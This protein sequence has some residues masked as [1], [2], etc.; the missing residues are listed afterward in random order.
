MPEKFEVPQHVPAPGDT[1]VA[2]FTHHNRP[3]VLLAIELLA[4]PGVTEN[5]MTFPGAYV[6]PQVYESALLA[7]AGSGAPGGRTTVRLGRAPRAVRVPSN[8]NSVSMFSEE[9]LVHPRSTVVQGQDGSYYVC[10]PGYAYIAG[11][12]LTKLPEQEPVT[13]PQPEKVAEPRR[14]G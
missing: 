9:S 14:K 6:V 3:P 5:G 1:H 7:V 2:L 11:E 4:P 13:P 10:P 8:S 12:G